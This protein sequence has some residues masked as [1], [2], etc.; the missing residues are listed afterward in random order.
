MNTREIWPLFK[1]RSIGL[2]KIYFV[3][4]L[5][6]SYTDKRTNWNLLFNPACFQQAL[7]KMLQKFLN[8]LILLNVFCCVLPRF[9]SNLLGNLLYIWQKTT[10][11]ELTKAIERTKTRSFKNACFP[12]FRLV[13]RSF[14]SRWTHGQ[15]SC[16]TRA[17]TSWKPWP[18]CIWCQAVL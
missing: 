4:H 8:I 18:M 7:R 2:I 9:W 6:I 15:T 3:L 13:F 14:L 17:S 12:R 10:T 1:L 5:F 16:T 11:I